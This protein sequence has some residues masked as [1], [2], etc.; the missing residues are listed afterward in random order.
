MQ[1]HDRAQV[2]VSCS[3]EDNGGRPIFVGIIERWSNRTLG[4]PKTKCLSTISLYVLVPNY[5][6]LVLTTIYLF[7]FVILVV[8]IFFY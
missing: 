5:P 3:S 4:L 1:V 2:F 6:I 7:L 8:T